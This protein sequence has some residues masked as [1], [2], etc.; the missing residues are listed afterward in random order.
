MSDAP[1]IISAKWK[2]SF[3]DTVD[4]LLEYITCS[5]LH[6]PKSHGTVGGEGAA[7][8]FPK[9]LKRFDESLVIPVD[10]SMHIAKMGDDEPFAFIDTTPR[11]LN[12]NIDFSVANPWCMA[13]DEGY[14]PEYENDPVKLHLLSLKRVNRKALRGIANVPASTVGE[15]SIAWIGVSGKYMTASTLVAWSS[16]KKVWMEIRP[17][18]SSESIFGNQ[19][20]DIFQVSVNEESAQSLAVLMGV[21][22]GL[23]YHWTVSLGIEDHPMLRFITDVEGSKAVFRL[24]DIPTGKKRR[25]ALK[26]W[27]SDHWR[28]DY[29]KP[30][31]IEEKTIEVRKHL[32]GAEEFHW[33]GLH[34]I[35][36]PS[37][38][39]LRMNEKLRKERAKR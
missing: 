15:Y 14:Y 7:G 29:R 13:D 26:N 35:V 16:K 19:N 10:R 8:R 30:A 18:D 25:A 21:K 23:D 2:R 38:F 4:D 28:K 12:Y 3:S 1:K 17:R 9:D 37:G 27:V 6:Q 33:N 20:R 31:P 22:F 5:T 36:R 11:D 24:R 39:D 34:C 32:R